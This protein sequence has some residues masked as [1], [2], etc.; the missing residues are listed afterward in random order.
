MLRPRLPLFSV[1]P[2]DSN[3][4]HILACCSSMLLLHFLHV[5]SM[6]VPAIYLNWNKTRQLL[7]K[8]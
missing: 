6:I 5:Y 3:E 2:D 4:T 8:F 1:Q 7:A